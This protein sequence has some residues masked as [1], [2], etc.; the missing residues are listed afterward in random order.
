MK[1]YE[2]WFEEFKAKIEEGYGIHRMDKRLAGFAYEAEKPAKTL[3]KYDHPITAHT[4]PRGQRM[5]MI[6]M[7][8]PTYRTVKPLQVGVRI[9]LSKWDFETPVVGLDS[10]MFGCGSN[11]A[12]REYWAIVKGISDNAG[13]TMETKKKGELSKLDIKE[14]QAWIGQN[15]RAYADTVVMPLQQKREL[16]KKGELWLP[17]KI[18]NGYVPEKD[19]GPYFAGKIDGANV[20]WMRFI[21][22]FALVCAKRENI[23]SNTPLKVYYDN[24]KRPSQLTIDKRCSS[25]PILEQ[26]VVKVTL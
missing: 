13:K 1:T 12:E 26:A 4:M 22:D 21:K 20:Y 2:E 17:H 9:D 7:P 8:T 24:P 3:W 19:R 16:L 10:Y 14:A 25:A 11:V 18:P 23:V 5:H 15:G 6:I